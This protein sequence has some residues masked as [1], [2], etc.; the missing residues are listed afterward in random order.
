MSA[1]ASVVPI[2]QQI[3]ALT[4]G[5]AEL[6]NQ[7]MRLTANYEDTIDRH[8]AG[9]THLTELAEA[10]Q[11]DMEQLNTRLTLLERWKRQAPP[12]I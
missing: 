12:D 10:Q 11:K 9:L 1:R 8:A 5:L 6:S 2:D 4:R 3:N 7:V